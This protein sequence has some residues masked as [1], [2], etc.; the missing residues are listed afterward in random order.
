[1]SAVWAK[2]AFIV[3]TLTYVFFFVLMKGE[4]PP[5]WTSWFWRAVPLIVFLHSA[6]VL[7]LVA[8]EL[9]VPGVQGLPRILF[10]F[11]AI[12]VFIEWRI[13]LWI[14]DASRPKEQ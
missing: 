10:G 14:L 2:P 12:I 5:A 1:M 9:E 3:F 6:V 13:S 8:I 11:L 4:Y 7:A